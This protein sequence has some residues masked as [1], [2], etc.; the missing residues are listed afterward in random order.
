M[1]TEEL[2]PTPKDVGSILR[3]AGEVLRSSFLDFL[4][5]CLSVFLLSFLC[6]CVCLGG[7]VCVM[8]FV[9][10]C[11]GVKKVRKQARPNSL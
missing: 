7:C 3:S 8:F 1:L 10:V 2:K 6:V 5:V 4:F 11:V 9:V